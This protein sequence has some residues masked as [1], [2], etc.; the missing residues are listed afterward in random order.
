MDGMVT[1]KPSYNNHIVDKLIPLNVDT[2]AKKKLIKM[3]LKE[4]C[5]I[6]R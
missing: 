6:L 4:K 1:H 2:V 3:Y 5:L